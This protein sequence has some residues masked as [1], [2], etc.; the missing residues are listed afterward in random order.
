MK[1]TQFAQDL[2]EA[3][4]AE[5]AGLWIFFMDKIRAT[6]PFLL[7]SAGRPKA[8]AVRSSAIGAAGFDSWFSMVEASPEQGGLGWSID[9]W[10]AWKRAYS[11]VIQ[12]GYLRNLELT[13]SEINTLSR[14]I[15]PF[16]TTQEVLES[17]KLERKQQLAAKRGNAV[18]ALRSQLNDSQESY[19]ALKVNFDVAVAE[20]ASQKEVSSA[21]D[22]E[23]AELNNGHQRAIGKLQRMRSEIA[24]LKSALVEKM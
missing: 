14:E 11:V 20:L 12:H 24:E 7:D 16:P 6:L 22:H 15:Q 21:R 2:R 8:D 10:K 18:S 3:L 19:K 9:S 1:P 4:G 23:Y 13:A 17:A 5:S